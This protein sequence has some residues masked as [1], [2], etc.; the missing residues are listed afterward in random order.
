MVALSSSVEL[1]YSLITSR[2]MD[3]SDGES[4]LKESIPQLWIA[5]EL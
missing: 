1:R 2:N 3:T 4:T 5:L